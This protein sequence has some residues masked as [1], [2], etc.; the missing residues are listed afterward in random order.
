MLSEL[1]NAVRWLSIFDQLWQLGEVQRLERSKCHSYFQELLEGGPRELTQVRLTSIPGKILASISRHMKDK[2]SWELSAW[3]TKKSLCLINLIGFYDKM[4][5]LV[6]D[7][8]AVDIVY[9]DF[10]KASETVPH[11]IFREK[12]LKYGLDEHTVR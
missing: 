2:T 1:A 6:D 3:I 10:S 7:G 11:K 9:L 8:R 12:L 5:G 4:T